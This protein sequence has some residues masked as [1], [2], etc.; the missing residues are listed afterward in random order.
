MGR[1]FSLVDTLKHKKEFK[2]RYR[3]PSNASIEHCNLGEW[4]EKRPTEAVAIPMIAFIEGG[5]RIP[6]GRVTRD[7]FILYRLCPTQCVPNM[8]RILS[9]VDSLNERIGINLT[10]HN[11][12]WVY[13]C[14]RNNEAGFY[15]KTKVPAIRLISCLPEMD[16]GMD[17]DFLIVS[18]EWHDGLHCPTKDGIPSR[19]A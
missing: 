8:F 10:H 16:K 6:M 2:K 18:G 4:H 3:I 19:V 12:N 14:Q 17:E 11:I 7:F 13:S 1:F 5:I 15:L 9:S